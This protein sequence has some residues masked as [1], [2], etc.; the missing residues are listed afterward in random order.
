M[1][2]NDLSFSFIQTSHRGWSTSQKYVQN[3]LNP[4]QTFLSDPSD[5]HKADAKCQM[6]IFWAARGICDFERKKEKNILGVV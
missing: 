3:P 6:G 2:N 4:S 1:S 5:E